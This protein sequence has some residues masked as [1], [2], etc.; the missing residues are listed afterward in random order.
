MSIKYEQWEGGMRVI[1]QCWN[2]K[3]INNSDL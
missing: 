3:N 2:F 1:L